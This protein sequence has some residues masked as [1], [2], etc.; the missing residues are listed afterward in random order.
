MLIHP[1]ADH[2]HANI[3]LIFSDGNAVL[4]RITSDKLTVNQAIEVFL[5]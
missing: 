3:M 1:P 4:A 2:L 5:N